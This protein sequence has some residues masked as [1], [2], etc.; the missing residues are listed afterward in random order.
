MAA[1]QAQV[2]DQ[3][4][5]QA[6]LS[7]G[8]LVTTFHAHKNLS[9]ALTPDQAHV[10]WAQVRKQLIETGLQ[11]SVTEIEE[12]GAGE[13]GSLDTLIRGDFLDALALTLTDR[14]FRWPANCDSEAYVNGC[15][16]LIK[17]A[18]TERGYVI[19]R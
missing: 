1:P 9:L 15:M 5:Q 17:A 8:A 3:Q 14:N 10:L 13:R 12:V 6:P 16:K 2:Q 19:E 11:E 18:I 4:A 7:G